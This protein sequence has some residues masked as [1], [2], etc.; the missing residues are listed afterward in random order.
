MRLLI[1]WSDIT[2]VAAAARTRLA[3]RTLEIDM[4]ELRAL[5]ESDAR[6]ASVRLDLCHPG[7]SCRIGR[8]FDVFAPRAKAEGGEDF[9]G[10]LGAIGRAGSGRTRALANV[11]VA[12]TDQQADSAATLAVID[13]SGPAALLSGFGQT[14]NV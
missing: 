5:L 1:E 13:M 12:V 7:E 8:V 9:P 4:E 3:G 14:H 6:L 2:A 11:A 10:V